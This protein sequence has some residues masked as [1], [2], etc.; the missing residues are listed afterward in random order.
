M[1]GPL[2]YTPLCDRV[3]AKVQLWCATYERGE[4]NATCKFNDP[5]L[6]LIDKPTRYAH[7]IAWTTAEYDSLLRIL[8]AGCEN[9][10]LVEELRYIRDYKL[11][12]GR[13]VLGNAR[14]VTMAFY[15]EHVNL[16]LKTLLEARDG[17]SKTIA[18]YGEEGKS[19]FE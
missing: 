2:W 14:V 3:L 12:H 6:G 16:I 4:V 7:A 10:A 15:R 9:K 1:P 13:L 11:P 5:Q 18:D 8:E 17:K 19:L